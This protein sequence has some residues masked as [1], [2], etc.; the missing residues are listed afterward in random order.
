MRTDLKNFNSFQLRNLESELKY[1]LT[2]NTHP[3]AREVISKRLMEVREV[4]FC[5]FLLLS[6][7]VLFPNCA[8]ENSSKH[9]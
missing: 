9:F 5:Q 7:D 6:L 4:C 1:L 2:E 3:R 8:F